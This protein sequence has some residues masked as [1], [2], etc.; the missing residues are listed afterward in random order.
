MVM[1]QQEYGVLPHALLNEELAAH[2]GAVDTMVAGALP[3]ERASLIDLYAELGQTVSAAE[4]CLVAAFD[5]LDS[6]VGGLPDEPAPTSRS[7][8]TPTLC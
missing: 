1:A 4:A 8:A 2:K 3:T 6:R 5:A 7:N